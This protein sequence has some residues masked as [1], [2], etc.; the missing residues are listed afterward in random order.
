[1]RP[2]VTEKK[3]AEIIILYN[4][5]QTMR[6]IADLFGMKYQSIGVLIS[7]F[8]KIKPGI[9]KPHSRKFIDYDEVERLVKAEGVNNGK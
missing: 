5:G 2:I 9:I 6:E 4:E 7:R 8:R 1:M 3:Y